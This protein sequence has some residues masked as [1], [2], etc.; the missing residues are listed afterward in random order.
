VQVLFDVKLCPLKARKLRA[1]ELGTHFALKQNSHFEITKKAM[2][3]KKFYA[4]AIGRTPG[5]YESWP[6]CERQ[7]NEC[8]DMHLLLSQFVPNHSFVLYNTR[9]K[10]FVAH[11][12]RAFLLKY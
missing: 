6:E 4:V 7:V 2:A 8:I 1:R 10:V 9:Q 12:S 3:K 11:A 5:V